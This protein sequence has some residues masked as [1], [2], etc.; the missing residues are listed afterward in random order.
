[1]KVNWDSN[2][3]STSMDFVDSLDIRSIIRK[4]FGKEVK[5]MICKKCGTKSKC[6]CAE[7]I[8]RAGLNQNKVRALL[9]ASTRKVSIAVHAKGSH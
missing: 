8:R 1:M 9:I 5:P 4:S 7:D 2:S 6:N 3:G